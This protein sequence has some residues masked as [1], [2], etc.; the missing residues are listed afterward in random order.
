[1]LENYTEN[2]VKI[3]RTDND[4]EEINKEIENYLKSKELFIK[5]SCNYTPQQNGRINNENRTITEAAR[6]MLKSKNLY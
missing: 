6:S 2:K 5:Q 4:L 1:M 3:L